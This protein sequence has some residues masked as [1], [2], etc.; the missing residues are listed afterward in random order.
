[1]SRAARWQVVQVWERRLDADAVVCHHRWRW[2]ATLCAVIQPVVMN[3]HYEVRRAPDRHFWEL[4]LEAI[5]SGAH[6]DPDYHWDP[7]RGE[8]VRRPGTYEERREAARAEGWPRESEA[9]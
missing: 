2:V 3:E 6:V 4:W 7:A 8:V 9:W 1:M 5:E